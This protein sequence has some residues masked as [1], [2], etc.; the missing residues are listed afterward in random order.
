MVKPST[1]GAWAANV[2]KDDIIA[3]IA[4]VYRD[5]RAYVDPS[6]MPHLYPKMRE[7]MTFVHS[8]ADDERYA[9]VAVEL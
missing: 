9:L 7:L 8:L 4:E 5:D 3:F 1:W 2:T 6:Y